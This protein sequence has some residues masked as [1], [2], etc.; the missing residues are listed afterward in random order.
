MI[1]I[2]VKI[3]N[4]NIVR[5]VRPIARYAIPQFVWDAVLNARTANS[6]YVSVVQL[7]ALNVMKPF[8]KIV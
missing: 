7:P 8:V 3:V 6:R 5:S 2:T 4:M 1:G